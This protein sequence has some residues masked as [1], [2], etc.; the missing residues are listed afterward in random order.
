MKKNKLLFWLL[1]SAVIMLL[2]PRLTYQ[3][4]PALLPADSG[5]A[6]AMLF[7]FIVNPLYAAL[8][9]FYAGKDRKT[10]WVSP[11]LVP[12]LFLLGVWNTGTWL[13]VLSGCYLVIGLLVMYISSLRK[14]KVS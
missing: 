12:I 7:Y 3:L 8:A 14:K 1:L 4:A 2:L 13:L 10:L 11:V 9:G 5:I 6:V